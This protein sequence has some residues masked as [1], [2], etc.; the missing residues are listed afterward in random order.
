MSNCTPQRYN[1]PNAEC[2]ISLRKRVLLK[3]FSNNVLK[4]YINLEMTSF[5]LL[6]WQEQNKLY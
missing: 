5:S 1:Q 3:C 6:E 4:V 2:H